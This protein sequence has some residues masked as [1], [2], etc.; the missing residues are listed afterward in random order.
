MGAD[1]ND[2]VIIAVKCFRAFMRYPFSIQLGRGQVA[3]QLGRRAPCDR[4]IADRNSRAKG[5]K[6]GHSI[7]NSTPTGPDWDSMITCFLGFGTFYATFDHFV[8]GLS[9]R[10]LTPVLNN[11]LH[12]CR[13]I[14]RPAVTDNSALILKPNL[15]CHQECFIRVNTYREALFTMNT[16][17]FFLHTIPA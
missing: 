4:P 5:R 14:K 13:S 6:K 16:L 2:V 11:V 15:S 7:E 1:V 3:S 8:A 12:C 9:P 17:P 10:T